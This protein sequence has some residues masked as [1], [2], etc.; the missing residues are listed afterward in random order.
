[1]IRGGFILFHKEIENEHQLEKNSARNPDYLRNHRE[2]NQ[3]VEDCM[4]Y[5]RM[6]YEILCGILVALEA[7]ITRRGK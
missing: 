4:K 7:I 3:V 1:M 6:A 2:R 5:I